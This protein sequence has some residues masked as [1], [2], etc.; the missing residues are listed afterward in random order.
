MEVGKER[1]HA[2]TGIG[3]TLTWMCVVES[4]QE[5][6]PRATHG[7]VAEDAVALT[8]VLGQ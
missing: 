7:A 6:R 5:R 1:E 8:S 3:G 4:S 2:Y